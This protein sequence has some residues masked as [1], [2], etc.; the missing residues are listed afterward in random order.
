MEKIKI[1]Q[2][3]IVEG[4]YDKIKLENIIDAFI[5]E[6]NGFGIFKDKEKLSF[7]KKLADERG[8]IILTDSDHAG[9][10]IRNHLTSAIPTEK[11]TNV[12]IPD[13]MGKEKR[14]TS[15][16]KEGK[17]GVEGMSKEILLE[18]LNKANINCESIEKGEEVT[19]YDLF[20]LGLSGTPNAKQN[21]KKLLK[22]LELP[23]FLSTSSLLSCINNM[24]TREEFLKIAKDGIN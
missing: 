22:K 15:P 7:I 3:V 1:R 4:K 10:M 6:T 8:I 17:I 16:S 13:I 11:I 9:F 14:K 5:L 2:A 12:Y 20:E 23:E 21:K 18:A 24:M 19:N